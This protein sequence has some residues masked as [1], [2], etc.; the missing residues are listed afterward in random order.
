V[1]TG[2]HYGDPVLIT[3][4]GVDVVEAVYIGF[5]G[6]PTAAVRLSG[7]EALVWVPRDWISRPE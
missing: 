7:T 5:A 4:P 2:L 1:I 6:G 3:A